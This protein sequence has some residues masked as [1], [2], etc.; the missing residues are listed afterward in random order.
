MVRFLESRGFNVVRIRGSHHFLE[1]GDRRTTVA[2]HGNE[3]IK[4][5]TL[6]SILRDLDLSP[7]EF[8]RLWNE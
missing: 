7:A 1:F 6:K 2:V 5:G 4:I 3:T 8:E